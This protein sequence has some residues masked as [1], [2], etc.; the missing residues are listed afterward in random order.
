[1]YLRFHAPWAECSNGS[2]VR[3]GFVAVVVVASGATKTD[4]VAHPGAIG[5]QSQAQISSIAHFAEDSDP[6]FQPKFDYCSFRYH[7]HRMHVQHFVNL[8]V[9]IL[10]NILADLRVVKSLQYL[11]GSPS[12][13]KPPHSASSAACTCQTG[14]LFQSFV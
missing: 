13:V 1:M 6:Y 5:Q 2:V 8:L 14:Q 10:A 11:S 9:R 3:Q 4:D 7:H 12:L